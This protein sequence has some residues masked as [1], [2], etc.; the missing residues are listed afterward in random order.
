[1]LLL[2]PLLLIVNRGPGIRST[3]FT[4]LL[5]Y[6]HLPTHLLC[7]LTAFSFPNQ[8]VGFYI[9]YSIIRKE[10]LLLSNAVMHKGIFTFTCE[11][12]SLFEVL[13]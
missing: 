11:F 10:Q 4:C 5:N 7:T 8:L 1:M 3:Q 2:A 13:V 9:T 6:A 12:V